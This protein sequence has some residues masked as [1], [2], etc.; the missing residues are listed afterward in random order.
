MELQPCIML[1]KTSV[2]LPTDVISVSQRFSP[3]HVEVFVDE[4]VNTKE[5]QS[6]THT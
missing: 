3:C 2:L 5:L 4:T 6:R 1:P